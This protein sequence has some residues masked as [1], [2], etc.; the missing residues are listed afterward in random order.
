MPFQ[1]QTKTTTT[2]NNHNL[3]PRW[4]GCSTDSNLLITNIQHCK[5]KLGSNGL[6]LDRYPWYRSWSAWLQW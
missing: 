5:Q 1:R 2:L 4:I 3:A 6:S